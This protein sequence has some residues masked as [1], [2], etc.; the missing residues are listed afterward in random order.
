MLLNYMIGFIN[1]KLRQYY[2]FSKDII[3]KY[4]IKKEITQNILHRSKNFIAYMA[5]IRWWVMYDWSVPHKDT[6]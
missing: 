3:D 6:N 1:K 5:R 4:N 2:V